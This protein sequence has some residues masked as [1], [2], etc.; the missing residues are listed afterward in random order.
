MTKYISMC[1]MIQIHIYIL[2]NKG[3][4]EGFPSDAIE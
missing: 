3:P 4:K 2:K 1:L